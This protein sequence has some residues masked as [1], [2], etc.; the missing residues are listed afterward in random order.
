MVM[1]FTN[2]IS[3]IPSA[4]RV[5]GLLQSSRQSVYGAG[6]TRLSNPKN[7]ERKFRGGRIYLWLPCQL[8]KT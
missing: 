2:K 6:D 7:R 5:A 1:Y 8:N 3:L 4:A